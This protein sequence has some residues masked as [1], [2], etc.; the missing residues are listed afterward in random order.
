MRLPVATV[1]FAGIS[2]C[3][4]HQGMS[5]MAATHPPPQVEPPKG[6]LVADFVDIAERAGLTAKASLGGEIA[7]HHIRE[8][9]GG[10]V[11]LIDFDHDGWLDIFV[12]SGGPTDARTGRSSTNHLY[13]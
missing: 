6:T 1:L 2:L 8:M 5:Q 7:N 13:R 10:G 3:V 12:L 9:T 4:T 11:A